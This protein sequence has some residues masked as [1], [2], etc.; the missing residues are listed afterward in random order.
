MPAGGW[1]LLLRVSDYG[2]DGD[3]MSRRLLERKV[4]A[5]SMSGWGE[6]HGGEFIRFVFSNEPVS[7]LD[8]LGARIRAAIG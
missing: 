8:G 7:R 1:S 4:A 5:T 6:R 2:L 3:E